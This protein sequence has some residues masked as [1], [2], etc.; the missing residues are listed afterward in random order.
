MSKVI[1]YASEIKKMQVYDKNIAVM[2]PYGFIDFMIKYL[3]FCL[4]NS[5]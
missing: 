3:L 5:Q 4:L 2:K 1:K